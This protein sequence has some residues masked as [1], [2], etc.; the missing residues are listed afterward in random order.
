MPQPKRSASDILVPPPMDPGFL[1]RVR[2]VQ[3][4]HYYMEIARTVATRANCTGARVGAA[5]VLDNRIIATGFN[6]TPAG[7]QN[8]LEGGC[9]RCR[10]RMLAKAGR[11]SEM[12]D[13]SLAGG[14]KQL[15]ICICVHAEAN[16]LLSAARAGTRTDGSVL[17]SN[18]KPCFTCLKDSIQAGVERVVY[19][20]NYMPSDNAVYKAQY[21]LLAEH[22]RNNDA[23]N[24]EQLARQR[25]VLPGA[26]VKLRAPV[27]DEL[28]ATIGEASLIEGPDAEPE[29]PSGKRRTGA[30]KE[31]S[32]AR[33]TA[34]SAAKSRPG[35]SQRGSSRRPKRQ[36]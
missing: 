35:G 20:N 28:I 23:R 26:D 27:L 3:W 31:A 1:D 18:Y 25:E 22:L 19:L 17:Y 2:Q 36:A 15:D 32:A 14:G 29:G 34:S 30:K 21:E 8:C 13:K 6:G 7:F 24:F 4:D 33:S 12:A 9:V 11:K 16:A 10:D 5:L